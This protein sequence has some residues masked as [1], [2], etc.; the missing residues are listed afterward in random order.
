MAAHLG[1]KLWL[2]MKRAQTEVFPVEMFE[3]S[4]LSWSLWFFAMSSIMKSLSFP[5]PTIL[6]QSLGVGDQTPWKHKNASNL[7]QSLCAKCYQLHLTVLSLVSQVTSKSHAIDYKNIWCSDKHETFWLEDWT[8]S[9]IYSRLG[10]SW[11]Q[12]PDMSVKLFLHAFTFSISS[13]STWWYGLSF[14]GLVIQGQ[15]PIVKCCIAL[16]QLHW[17]RWDTTLYWIG[18]N[19]LWIFSF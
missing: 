13:E 4:W 18:Q 10:N 11:F 1:L 12:I 7:T 8:C 17:S 6:W 15:E 5:A 14:H 9:C 3:L 16:M 19:S 2:G